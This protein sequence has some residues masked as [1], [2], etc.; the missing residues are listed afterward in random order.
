[1][2]FPRTFSE[3]LPLLL[4]QIPREQLALLS[5]PSDRNSWGSSLHLLYEI[6]TLPPNRR[7]IYIPPVEVSHA[8]YKHRDE[9]IPKIGDPNLTYIISDDKIHGGETLECAIRALRGQGVQIKDMWFLVS[10]IVDYDGTNKPPFFDVP[11]VFLAYCASRRRL[12]P[13]SSSR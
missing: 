2:R 6:V 11:D 13:A 4:A 9:Q 12:S 7:F 3:S 10:E 5:I 1:M 8:G